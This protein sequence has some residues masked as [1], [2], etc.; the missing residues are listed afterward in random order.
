MKLDMANAFDRVRH[1]FL[2]VV[3]H[4]FGLTYSFI[5]WIQACIGSPY[6]SPLVNGRSASIFLLSRGLRQGYPLRN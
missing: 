4:Q 2:Y 6:I 3:L 1:S 5:H